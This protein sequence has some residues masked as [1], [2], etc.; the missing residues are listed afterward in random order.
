VPDLA[1]TAWLLL[2]AAALL[3]GFAKTSIGGAASISVAVFAA[4]LPSRESTGTLLPLLL[5]GDVMAVLIYRRHAN[6]GLLLRLLPWVAAGTVLGAVFVSRVDDAVMRRVIGVV[7]LGLVVV[8]LVTRGGRLQGDVGAP[9]AGRRRS[10]RA[11]AAAVGVVAGFATMVANAA[12]PVMTLYLLMAGL[13]MLEFLGTAAWFFLIV[14]AVK[15]P[16]SVGLGLLD[17]QA[18]LF[19]LRLVPAV[20]VGAVVGRYVIRRTKQKQ[21]EWAALMLTAVAAVPLLL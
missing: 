10:T 3:V 1:V 7:L 17:T 14:N 8:Q 11:A 21:F 4:V 12:G 18:L 9:T 15:V 2:A 20:V 6:W 13:P 5:V 16:F 19:D